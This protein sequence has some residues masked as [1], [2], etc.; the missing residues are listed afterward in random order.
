M[1]ISLE[2]VLVLVG[3]DAVHELD[4]GDVDAEVGQ[5]VGELHADGTGT[6]DDHGLR[7]VLVEDLLLVGDDVAADL[8]SRQGLHHGAGGDDGVVE[9]DLLAGVVTVGDL[10]GV[11]VGEGTDT[12]DLGDLVLLHQ[13]VDALDDARGH[14]PGPLVG[15]GVVHADV[16]TADAEGLGIVGEDVRDVRVTD[17]RLGGDAADVQ[18]D[19]APVL[20]L[21]YRGLQAQLC[22][23]DGGHVSAGARTDYYYVIMFSHGVKDTTFSSTRPPPGDM[24]QCSPAKTLVSGVTPGGALVSL[25]RGS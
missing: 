23:T 25:R 12:V 1:A 3:Q 16:V 9:G 20:L 13:V 4:D 18:T 2:N 5:D 19:A 7:G 8:H 15:G 11:G 21:D 24:S 14:L 10:D 6:D 17:Q 22:R